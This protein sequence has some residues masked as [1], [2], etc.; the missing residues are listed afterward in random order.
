MTDAPGSPTAAK[1]TPPWAIA[2]GLGLAQTVAFGTTTYFLVLYSEPLREEM[3]WGLHWVMAGLTVAF[4][5]WAVIAGRVGLWMREKGGKPALCLST[6]CFAAGLLLIAVAHSIPVYLLAWAVIGVGMGTG[7]YDAVFAT[8]GRLY[9]IEARRPITTVTLVGGFSSTIFWPIGGLLI[10]LIGWRWTGVAFAA[11]HLLVSLPIYL[12]LLPD[13][14]PQPQGTAEAGA[15]PRTALKLTADGRRA[16]IALTCVAVSHVTM[17]SIISLN[18]I[19]I[20]KSRG[21]SL[22]AAIGLG[23][24]I[25]PSQVASR[26]IETVLARRYHPS[27][28]MLVAMFS[29]AFSALLLVILPTAATVVALVILGVGMGLYSVARGALPIYLYGRMDSAVVGA[30]IGRYVAITQAAAPLAGA[31]L[32]T[33]VGL[34]ST[35][36]VLVGVG[37]VAVSSTLAL[38]IY[39]KRLGVSHD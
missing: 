25:G 4:L 34:R 1:A 31:W 32:V 16:L 11:M 18:M 8:L 30:R 6:F 10:S 21:L 29:M 24:V 5:V 19:D 37:V 17:S 35:L 27:A 3:G 23:A 26:L 15:G 33:N 12:K 13:A 36:V 14:T 39:G 2:A 22:A 28:T 7:L 38:R 20:L 9:G